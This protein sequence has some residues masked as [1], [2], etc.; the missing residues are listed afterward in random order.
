VIPIQDA[1]PSGR[2]PVVTV[3]L[4]VINLAWFTASSAAGVAPSLA[5]SPFSHA[6]AIHL[7]INLMFLW[8][9]GDNVEARVG[10][11][12]FAVLYLACS[13][14]G[15]YVATR[16]V[17]AEVAQI[18]ATCAVS[19]VLGAYFVLLPKSRMLIL[20]PATPVLTEAPALFFLT[21]WWM[22]QVATFV[23]APAGQPS[24]LL[25]PLASFVL[26]AA[27]CLVIRRPVR[28]S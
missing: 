4:I 10:R 22:L 17:D 13:M 1:V 12:P 18:G 28:W 25:A 23:G 14:V 8:L 11:A 5:L 19:G 15:T 9:F 21:V 16:S 3:A 2:A 26:G 27:I 7:F 24:L 6:T 20:V